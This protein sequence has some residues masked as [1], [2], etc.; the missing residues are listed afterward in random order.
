MGPHSL[1]SGHARYLAFDDSDYLILE[2]ADTE[3]PLSAKTA[4]KIEEIGARVPGHS[5]LLWNA[6]DQIQGVFDLD[7]TD[8]VP[9]KNFEPIRAVG[10]APDLGHRLGKWTRQERRDDGLWSVV[11]E[12]LATQNDH[13]SRMF[14]EQILHPWIEPGYDVGIDS[15]DGQ[16]NAYQVKSTVKSL[17]R[18]QEN[19]RRLL[20]EY[21]FIPKLRNCVLIVGGEDVGK[22]AWLKYIREQL[23]DKKRFRNL[24]LLTGE[25]HH[26]FDT[27]A[28]R[29][30]AKVTTQSVDALISN[31]EATTTQALDAA[32]KTLPS[33]SKS[34]PEAPSD[35]I[36][37][38]IE[39][40][41]NLMQRVRLLDAAEWAKWRG[42]KSKNPS[43]ALGKYKHQNRVFAVR[44][45][46]RDLYPAFQ[47]SE[48]AEPLPV[49]EEILKIVPKDNQGWP[50]L[51]WFEAGSATLRNRKPSDV[52]AS[53]PAKVIE[54]ARRFYSR[55]D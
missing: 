24:V 29:H 12:R 54:A 38:A 48:N 31:L 26:G 44:A 14:E 30:T 18:T 35:P 5:V 11:F 50:L 21:Q 9:V 27:R 55:D 15:I 43:A 39:I 23:A 7:Q 3:S 52:L 1:Y 28:A 49:I 34:V 17:Q 2:R 19:M 36:Q 6:D 25:A 10:V 40:R 46:N 13:I 41:K 42:A 20:D 53:A 51:S 37:N 45:G 4:K 8:R 32:S 16:G 22:S 47:F 33:T